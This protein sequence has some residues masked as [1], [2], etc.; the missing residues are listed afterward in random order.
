M[1]I[2]IVSLP[3]TGS[4]VLTNS[5]SKYYNIHRFLEPFNINVIPPILYEEIEKKKIMF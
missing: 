2:L 1:K 5:I 3:R 4:T